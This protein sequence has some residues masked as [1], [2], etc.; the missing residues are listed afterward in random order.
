MDDLNQILQ[1]LVAEACNHP[2]KSLERRQVLSQVYC[3]VMQSGKL[4]K[5]YAPYY[6]DAVQ[7]MWEFCCQNPE[8]YDPTVKSV[9]TWLDDYLKKR[10]RNFRDARYRQRNREIAVLQNESGETTDAIANLPALPEIQPVLDIW[11]HTLDWV[12]QDHERDG[13]LCSTCFRKRCEVNCQALILRR[14]P[15]ETPWSAI[16]QNFNLTPAEAKD[17]PKFYNRKCLPLLREFAVLQG[18]VE[19]ETRSSQRNSS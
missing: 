7:E 16:A 1:S 15:S 9:I 12:E 6:N 8:L 17:L 4:W 14:F 2:P 19:A 10:L 11:Q 3:L 13:V 18:Y 5:E